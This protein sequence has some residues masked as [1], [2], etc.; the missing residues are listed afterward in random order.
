MPDLSLLFYVLESFLEQ[1]NKASRTK[2]SQA[3]TLAAL[4]THGGSPIWTTL[5]QP[6]TS[7]ISCSEAQP[8][9]HSHHTKTP[10]MELMCP[11]QQQKETTTLKWDV[12]CNYVGSL[13]RGGNLNGGF[14][15]RGRMSQREYRC[16]IYKKNLHRCRP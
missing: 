11:Q 4:E 6:S 7:V 2:S 13:Y 10:T 16:V 15:H 14:C 9:L 1:S 3:T 5:T 12:L 8:N